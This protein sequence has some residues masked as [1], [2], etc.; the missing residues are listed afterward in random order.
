MITVGP[1]DVIIPILDTP[2]LGVLR[3]GGHVL[4]WISLGPGGQ[5]LEW[6]PD[7]VVD[8]GDGIERGVPLQVP[9]ELDAQR[10]KLDAGSLNEVQVPGGCSLVHPPTMA[11][12]PGDHNRDV[13]SEVLMPFARRGPCH[14]RRVGRLCEDAKRFLA[15]RRETVDPPKRHQALDSARQTASDTA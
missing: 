11:D 13:C 9:H 14:D 4:A 6:P 5:D 3:H 12:G 2:A 7:A 10:S 8:V 15:L 1:L